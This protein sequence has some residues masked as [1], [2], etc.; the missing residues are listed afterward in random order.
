MDIRRFL[1]ELKGRG[2][3]RVAALYAAGSWALLQ[4]ADVF[5]PILG[6]P[7]WA[8]TTFLAA[9]ALGF[10]VTILLAW[11]FE[12]TPAGIVETDSMNEV[13][14]DP[15]APTTAKARK[16]SVLYCFIYC[17]PPYYNSFTF[18]KAFTLL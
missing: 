8:I 16:C 13:L 5:F 9:A 10:P 14:P 4:L 11:I 2:V 17:I 3:Y 6:L 7:D 1:A 18:M 12:I 15:G